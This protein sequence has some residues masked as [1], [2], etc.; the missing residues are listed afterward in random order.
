M[1]DGP[2]GPR[3]HNERTPA[4]S[5]SVAIPPDLTEPAAR[6]AITC[7]T[8]ATIDLDPTAGAFDPAELQRILDGRYAELRAQIREVMSRPEFDPPLEISR[9]DYRA[10]VMGWAL[11]ARRGGRHRSGLPGPVRRRAATSGPTSA[12]FETIAFGD[13]S[14][15][16]KFGVQFGLFG[17]AVQQLGTPSATTSA[18]CATSHR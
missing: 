2:A 17:G 9:D 16:V 14:L 3:A 12:G 11:A 5:L 13:L 10:T 15:L 7:R 1:K 4:P 18:T 8:M 6:R